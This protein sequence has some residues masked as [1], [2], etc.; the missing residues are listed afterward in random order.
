MELLDDL[1]ST[2]QDRLSHD[3]FEL[4]LK[5]DRPLPSVTVDSAALTQ[6]I[7]NLVDN[8]VKY[9]GSQKKAVVSA[10]ADDEYL[11]ISVKDFGI[12]IKREELDK[13]FDRFYRG[14]DEL[15]RTVKGSGL[16]LTLVKQ[17]IEAHGGSVQ[18]ESEPG[19]GSTFSIRIP[20]KS[21]KGRT[22]E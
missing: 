4:L 15:T 16:G 8:A 9:S 10:T 18:V 21:S 20:L 2:H 17:I 22:N 11:K 12:G 13:V 1:I 5:A 14:G 19:R 6:A 3:S 7:N